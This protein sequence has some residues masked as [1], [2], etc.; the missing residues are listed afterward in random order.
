VNRTPEPYDLICS[1][2]EIVDKLSIENIKC[3]DANRKILEERAKQNPSL[4]VIS[5]CEFQARSSGEQRVRLKNELNLRLAE[6]IQRGGFQA[7]PE[8]RTYSQFGI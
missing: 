4:Q 8:V 2:G 3:Y 6:A 7:N 1:I 5:A